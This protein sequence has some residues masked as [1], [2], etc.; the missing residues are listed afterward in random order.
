MAAKKEDWGAGLLI[1]A[2]IAGNTDE[3]SRLIDD[4]GADL[5]KKDEDGWCGLMWACHKK[6]SLDIVKLLV[7]KGASVSATDDDGDSCLM[8]A[9]FQG[10]LDIAA[11]LVSQGASIGDK[12]NNGCSCLMKACYTGHFD[13]IAFLVSE[14]A[15]INHQDNDG[16]SCLMVACN[17]GYLHIAEYLMAQ[18]ASIHAMSNDGETSF[19]FAAGHSNPANRIR[20]L[21]RLRKWPTTM[22]ILVLQELGL[23]DVI[24]FESAIDL[25][26]YLGRPED[27]TVDDEEKYGDLNRLFA[28]ISGPLRCGIR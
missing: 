5:H 10:H 18:G 21:Y 26:Q 4:E 8:W 27:F 12:S 15:D 25:H 3:C 24:D 2:I 23:V 13:I 20:L 19:S 11:F 9:C 28:R 7:S 14:G 1:N 16:N 22:A 6:G 17:N